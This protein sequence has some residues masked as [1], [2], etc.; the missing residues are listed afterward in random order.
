MSKLSRTAALNFDDG[1]DSP[2]AV[3]ASLGTTQINRVN[4]LRV[5][6][7]DQAAHVA[8]ILGNDILDDQRALMAILKAQNEL[9]EDAGRLL[10]AA[11]GM[12]RT[13]NDLQREVGRARFGQICKY[14]SE[15]FPGLSRGNVAKLMAV[16]D[17]VDQ[18]VIHRDL[19]P[20]TYTVVY[21]L[22]T[23]SPIDV[24][25]AYRS[26]VLRPDITRRELLNWKRS[27]DGQVKLAAQQPHQTE[28]V[29]LAALKQELDKI[30]RDRGDFI[31]RILVLRQR[32]HEIKKVI[33]AFGLSEE[34]RERKKLPLS[35]GTRSRRN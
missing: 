9:R 6:T 26:G 21:E 10:D 19:L 25:D 32:E 11:I 2:V 13:L 28:I 20:P 1:D 7:A 33:Q 35:S 27:L 31:K 24:K 30:Q 5:V 14:S 16:A 34:M 3:A 23:I 8:T 12:G 22:T 18:R 29:R 4:D 15:L 17:F